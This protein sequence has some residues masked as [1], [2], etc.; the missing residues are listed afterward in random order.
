V[1]SLPHR[2]PSFG[3]VH[4]KAMPVILTSS[5][6]IELRMS[7]PWNEAAALQRLLPDGALTIV[8]WGQE[9]DAVVERS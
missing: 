2:M 9:E 6:E 7:V 1:I 8:A 5:E 4:A 3:A